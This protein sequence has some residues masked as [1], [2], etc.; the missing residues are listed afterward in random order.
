MQARPQISVRSFVDKNLLF[1]YS[2]VISEPCT[3]SLIALIV[4]LSVFRFAY[5][6]H[7]ILSEEWKNYDTVLYL[8]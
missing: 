3:K 6:T 8:A 4:A 1:F 5:P 2:R 7:K